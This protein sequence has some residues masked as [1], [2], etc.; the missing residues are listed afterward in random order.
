MRFR[1]FGFGA[2][3]RGFGVGLRGDVRDSLI[4]GAMASGPGEVA[5]GMEQGHVSGLGLGLGVGR[6]GN[7]WS[8]ALPVTL[9]I[10]DCPAPMAESA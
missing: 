5:K 9:P 8:P 4:E 3:F 6:R 2:G 10:K 7:T 1:L